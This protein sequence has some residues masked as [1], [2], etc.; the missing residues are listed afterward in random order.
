M[1]LTLLPLVMPSRATTV[2]DVVYEQLLDALHHG[3]LGPGDQLSDH[4]LANQLGVSRT[5]VRE[6][7]LRLQSIGVVETAPARYT[8]VAIIDR[9]Q[10]LHAVAVWAA[11]YRLVVSEVFPSASTELVARMRAHADRYVELRTSPGGTEPPLARHAVIA[12]AN[13]YLEPVAE[14]ANAV[15][16]RTIESVQHVVRL[17][18]QAL[19]RPPSPEGVMRDH[20]DLLAAAAAHDVLAGQRVFDRILTLVF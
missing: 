12:N 6:A 15:L 9:Q 16:R 17:G 5:P 18:G 8:R 4:E 3:R 10:T 13:F 19:E 14:S 20:R 11:L 1:P 7:L 2:G